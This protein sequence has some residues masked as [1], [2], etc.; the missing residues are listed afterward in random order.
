MSADVIVD[1][2][3]RVR[4]ELVKCYGGLDGW[5]EHLQELDRERAGKLQRPT[6]KKS[7]RQWT[8]APKAIGQSTGA[9]GKQS[10]MTRSIRLHS[11]SCLPSGYLGQH[12]QTHV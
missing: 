1:E 10:E 12:G 8:E 11:R 3:R 5:I 9:S 4:D 2:V 6:A 7:G